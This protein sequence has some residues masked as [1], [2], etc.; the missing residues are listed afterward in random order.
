MSEH[1]FQHLLERV[2]PIIQRQDTN[3][4]EAIPTSKNQIRSN[5]S[6]FSNRKLFQEFRVFI[7]GSKIN[8]K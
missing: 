6:V 5:S 8:N 7:Q 1:H 3:M 4:R 2:T